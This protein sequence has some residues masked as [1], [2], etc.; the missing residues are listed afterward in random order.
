MVSALSLL[1]LATGLSVDCKPST[2]VTLRPYR[3][4]LEQPKGG[5]GSLR[6][7]CNTS[8]HAVGVQVHLPTFLRVKPH[9]H[10]SHF[11]IV[12]RRIKRLSTKHNG[13]HCFTAEASYK[14]ETQ[15]CINLN[16]TSKYTVFRALGL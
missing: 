5:M 14:H 10:A 16:V 2:D 12:A 3:Y 11:R 6:I 8:V 15:T 13:S 4:G 9:Q 1:L 7:R